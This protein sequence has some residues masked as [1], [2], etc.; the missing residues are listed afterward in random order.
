MHTRDRKRNVLPTGSRASTENDAKTS[1][2]ASFRA[3]KPSRISM[4]HHTT[5]IKRTAVM[6][7]LL[8]SM[9]HVM[10]NWHRTIPWHPS[11]E[12]LLKL[13]LWMQRRRGSQL[14]G[15]STAI[16]PRPKTQDL[17]YMVGIIININLVSFW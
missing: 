16:H 11:L 10:S 14:H 12:V 4:G 17:I 5:P 1:M 3:Q 15:E 8:C 6:K 7:N 9:D 2:L 13:P